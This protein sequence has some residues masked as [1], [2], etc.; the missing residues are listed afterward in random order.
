MN[1]AFD[2]QGG[3][4][5]AT[6]LVKPNSKATAPRIPIKSGY[7]LDGWYKEAAGTHVWS[8]GTSVTA[9][10]TL[11]AKW[12]PWVA[13]R[14]KLIGG[15]LQRTYYL[16]NGR[17]SR[18]EEYFGATVSTGIYRTHYYTDG[19]RTSYRVFYSNG[20]LKNIIELYG[21]GNTKKVN[22]YTTAGVRT[23]FKLYDTAGRMTHYAACYSDGIKVKK[24][25]YYNVSTG[26]RTSF[27]QYDT[28]GRMTH[29]AVTYSDGIKVKK[30][31]YY[32][33]STGIRKAYKTYRTDGS[34]SCYV[35]CD[36]SGNRIKATYYD[37]D[38]DVTKVVT[39]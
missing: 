25:N 33:A 11:Y 1:V 28:A 6:Q 32:I 10:V 16:A 12:S 14:D 38:G 17:P 9:D 20:K 2:S 15:K 19:L 35:V 23:S 29:Y 18:V 26:K 37:E 24:L 4:S 13:R 30:M 34:C 31:N 5:V 7:I 3:S 27:K 21:N 22:Y 8:F 36:S 39:Y